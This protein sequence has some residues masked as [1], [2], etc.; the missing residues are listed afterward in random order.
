MIEPEDTADLR[1]AQVA[2]LEL[3]T[4]AAPGTARGV[5]G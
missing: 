3:N 2:S 1:S 5:K 4:K